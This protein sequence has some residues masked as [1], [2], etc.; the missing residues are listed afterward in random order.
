MKRIKEIDVHFNE[1]DQVWMGFIQDDTA[2]NLI[3]QDVLPPKELISIL[4]W[5]PVQC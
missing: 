1:K 3:L 2:Q 4:T 5:A